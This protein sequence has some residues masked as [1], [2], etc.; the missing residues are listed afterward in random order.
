MSGCY[1]TEVIC[2]KCGNSRI[3]LM[4]VGAICTCEHPILK[5]DLEKRI[6]ALEQSDKCMLSMHI[7]LEKILFNERDKGVERFKKI[8]DEVKR[9]IDNV[10]LIDQTYDEE[11]NKIDERLK[12]LEKAYKADAEVAKDII[13]AGGQRSQQLREMKSDYDI[14]CEA[15]SNLED[16][17]KKLKDSL[18]IHQTSLE[19]KWQSNTELSLRLE[20]LES[21]PLEN[22]SIVFT[23]IIKRI[24]AL[25]SKQSPEQYNKVEAPELHDALGIFTGKSDHV[26]DA[27]NYLNQASCQYNLETAPELSDEVRLSQQNPVK[28]CPHG[29]KFYCDFCDN[30]TFPQIEAQQKCEP[31]NLVPDDKTVKCS[32][33]HDVLFDEGIHTC[34][35]KTV[36]V[37]EAIRAFREG[38]KVHRINTPENVY[39]LPKSNESGFHCFSD[40]DALADDWII[41]DD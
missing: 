35:S 36:S 2:R 22:G 14:H 30:K 32:K 33:C 41:K 24:E 31:T 8:E 13:F 1:P 26:L 18:S 23:T 40:E 12:K 19:R 4:G 7:G 21:L 37:Y 15:I 3:D 11:T 27:C 28:K 29:K 38:K 20:A 25:E 16:E 17:V 6:E 5:N 34:S 9:W 10:A 39:R